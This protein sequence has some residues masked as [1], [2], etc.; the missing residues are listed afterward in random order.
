MFTKFV[1]T[2]AGLAIAGGL[3]GGFVAPGAAFAGG[4]PVDPQ[5]GQHAEI[6]TP[7]NCEWVAQEAGGVELECELPPEC[8][9]VTIDLGGGWQI[10]TIQ[11][12]IESACEL[13]SDQFLG[14]TYWYIDCEE[15]EC[16]PGCGPLTPGADGFKQEPPDPVAPVGRIIPPEPV[17][18]VPA[19]TVR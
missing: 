9:S 10:S 18:F 17:K 5:P 12:D 13:K 4:V 8:E 6:F 3:L 16:Y 14:T 19:P 11:C 15:S 2:L 1:R 7:P